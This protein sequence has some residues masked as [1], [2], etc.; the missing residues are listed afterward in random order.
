[1]IKLVDLRSL[2]DHQAVALTWQLLEERPIEASISH[3]QMPSWEKHKEYVLNHPYR[4]WNAIDAA[5]SGMVGT[6]LLTEHNEIGIAILREH[7]RRGYARAAV[8]MLMEEYRPAAEIA[9]RRSG[10]F[11]ANVNPHNGASIA[12][13]LGLGGRLIQHTYEL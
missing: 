3:R 5:G 6:V 4:V 7:Q 10:Y 12:L 13:F 1:M 11:L 9:G 8:K 2:P